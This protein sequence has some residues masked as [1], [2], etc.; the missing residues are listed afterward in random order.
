MKTVKREFFDNHLF[1]DSTGIQ[2]HLS[3]MAKN[4]WI[5]E[6]ATS[7]YWQYR[8]GEP[9]DLQ[10]T[11][12]YFHEASEFNP[13]PTDNQSTFLEYCESSGWNFVAQLAQMQIFCSTQP[14]PTPIETDDKLKL[15]S[16]HRSMKK[17]FLPSQIL[18]LVLAISQLL[19]RVYDY[20]NR[21][22]YLLSD[23]TSLL[24]SLLFLVLGAYTI[25][26]IA[27]YY[28]WQKRARKSLDNGGDIP[29]PR[30]SSYLRFAVL[31]FALSILLIWC[32]VATQTFSYMFIVGYLAFMVFLFVL[33]FSVKNFLKKKKVSAKK[34]RFIVLVILPII[35]TIVII[36]F[37]FLLIMTEVSFFQQKPVEVIPSDT[38]EGRVFEFEVYKDDIP[39]KLEDFTE[40]TDTTYSYELIEQTE[41]FILKVT[42][43]SQNGGFTTESIKEFQYKIVDVKIP[44][45][46]EVALNDFIERFHYEQDVDIEFRRVYKEVSIPEFCANKVYQL[47][48]GDEPIGNDFIVCYDDKIVDV[49]FDFDVTKDEIARLSEKLLSL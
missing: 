17:N 47:H 31:L 25:Y 3:E 19:M 33:S 40:I 20:F 10:Y 27:G 49:Y 18:I 44:F 2:D 14:N 22:L 35:L 39:I 36:N 4:G 32:V 9:Q 28:N 30:N 45:F 12:T 13:Y 34:S 46:Y 37:V 6:K 11:V 24:V 23:Y 21:P 15:K 43:A 29:R 7:F 48:R 1:Y 16:I 38:Q 41:T 5:F 8:K 26:I 42:H